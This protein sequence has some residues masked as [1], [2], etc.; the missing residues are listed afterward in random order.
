MVTDDGML[1]RRSSGTGYRDPGNYSDS[2]SPPFYLLSCGTA[3][4][5]LLNQLS[6]HTEQ[7]VISGQT[8][9]KKKK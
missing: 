1:Y 7:D 9:I 4:T 6:E 5:I 8:M 3:P 2:V